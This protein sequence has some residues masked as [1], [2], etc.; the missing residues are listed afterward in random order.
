MAS[1]DMETIGRLARS[2]LAANEPYLYCRVVPVLASSSPEQAEWVLGYLKALV[3]L[4][5]H[6]AAR[7]LIERFDDS[8]LQEPAIRELANAVSQTPHSH[9]PWTS[10]RRRFDANLAGLA[11]RDAQAAAAVGRAWEEAQARYEMHDGGDGNVQVREVSAVWP[12]RWV[13]SLDDH[14]GRAAGR[15]RTDSAGILPPPLLF[16]GVGLGWEILEGY[17]RTRRVFLEASAAVYIVEPRA[18]AVGLVFHLHDWRELLADESVYWF[19]G[20]DAE[21]RFGAL[22]DGDATLPLT[23]RYCYSGEGEGPPARPV[24]SVLAQ[25]GARRQ[26]RAAALRAQISGVYAGRDATYWARRFDEAADD[27]GRATKHR[28]RVLGLTSLY[29]TFLQYSM[30]DCLRAIEGLGHETRLLIEPAAH[31]CLDPTTALQ[32]QLEFAPDL[33]LILSRMRYE[34]PDLIHESIPTVTWDQDA[35]PWVFEESRRPTL[36]WN[37]FLMGM[38]AMNARRKFGWPAHRCRFFPM[39]GGVQTYSETRL[40][41]DALEPYRCDVSYVS[42]AS[43]VPE[44]EAQAVESWLPN[45]KLRVLYRAAVAKLLPEWT[46]GGAFPGPTMTAIVDA[47]MEGSCSCDSDERHK[48]NQALHRV[49]DRA[50]RHAA[51]EWVAD[52]AESTGRVFLL[53]G[54]GWDQH[55]RLARFARG[56]TQ[57]G[58]A[59]RRVYQGSTI[60]LQ[61]MGF[62]FL[63]QRAFD[64]VMAG[65]FFMARRSQADAHG[66]LGRD[67]IRSLDEAGVCDAAGIA[68]LGDGKRRGKI[69][70]LLTAM[71]LD[72][73]VLDAGSTET[74]RFSAENDYAADVVPHFDE[75]TFG[76]PEEFAERAERFLR[77]PETRSRYATHMRQA[78]VERYSYDARMA[79]MIRFVRDGFRVD[80]GGS[81]R[82]EPAGV[83]RITGAADGARPSVTPSV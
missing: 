46:A 10:R 42:H 33:V 52:W 40:G 43:R 82:P 22:L 70:T 61:L 44:E 17:R 1:I 38:S 35:L 30:R 6:G 13:R 28:L 72:A 37:D 66:A 45:E 54:N 77:E 83:W 26:S 20:A 65:G 47:C 56:A 8:V 76:G 58:E 27:A 63:H 75:I 55:P 69:E 57:N 29:T 51:L 53:W 21:R 79:D 48:I 19:I 71:G 60:N 74:L 73:R 14:R 4:G 34:M 2:A 41:A 49:G 81:E 9:V 36:A 39:A 5:L 68:S 80:A 7:D 64:G 67:L 15:V 50:F 25:V 59:L 62:G 16:E 31:R 23:D 12:A 3:R 24:T 11:R 32:A 78:L 18:E